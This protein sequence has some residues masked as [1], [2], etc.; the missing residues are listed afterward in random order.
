MKKGIGLITIQSDNYGNRLQ[1]YAVQ[2]LFEAYGFD[3]ATYKR[4]YYYSKKHKSKIAAAYIL[5]FLKPVIH[6]NRIPVKIRKVLAGAVHINKMNQFTKDYINMSPKFAENID[7]EEIQDKDY[8]ICG[9]DQL[10]NPMFPMV[11][12]I[13]FLFFSPK[14]KNISVAASIGVDQLPEHCV[15]IYRL[16]MKNFKAISVRE[17][18]AKAVL[19]QL[20]DNEIEVLADPTMTLSKADWIK[21]E[22]AVK[23]PAR[24]IVVYLLDY[25]TRKDVLD[26]LDVIYGD[27]RPG[28]I[29]ILDKEHPESYWFGPCEFLYVIHHADAVFTDSFHGT[30][31]SLLFQRNVRIFKRHHKEFSMNSRLNTLISKLGLDEDIMIEPG[32]IKGQY[33]IDYDAVEEKLQKERKRYKKFLNESLRQ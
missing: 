30:V 11:S 8:F 1:N 13:D 22:K 18:Q 10:W 19:S 32:N 16:Y 27:G 7:K 3:T 2:K 31:F 17:E 14:E 12:E 28:I 26:T 21:L 24:Y 6:I 9:S 4:K 20:T 15:E 33:K 5:K 29:W 25:K 23:V